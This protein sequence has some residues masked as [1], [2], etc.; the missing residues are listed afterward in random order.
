MTKNQVNGKAQ[1]IQEGKDAS[2]LP[3]GKA[4]GAASAARPQKDRHKS[5][6]KAGATQSKDMTGPGQDFGQE[7]RGSSWKAER[8]GDKTLQEV[9]KQG[10]EEG[11]R[12]EALIEKQDP[13]FNPDAPD[14]ADVEGLPEDDAAGV[15]DEEED[16]GDDEVAADE[17]AERQELGDGDDDLT[18]E[19]REAADEVARTQADLDDEEEEE[20]EA[21]E[22][23][24]EEEEDLVEAADG[25][26]A[27]AEE[28]PQKGKGR[29]GGANKKSDK[30]SKGGMPV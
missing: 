18:M 13:D 10:D 20:D 2:K 19:E 3:G 5:S 11:E 26:N 4:G 29:G 22:E 1:A 12:T 17:D 8:E 23:E 25:G 14:D 6:K 21:D 9:A 16:V 15:D 28:K 27:E 30:G 7:I 24:E